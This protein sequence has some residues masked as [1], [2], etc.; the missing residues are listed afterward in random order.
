M[1]GADAGIEYFVRAAINRYYYYAFW[2]VRP[3]LEQM[4]NQQA[5]QH[6]RYTELLN[7]NLVQS[8]EQRV[9]RA[10]K[11]GLVAEA[12]ATEARELFRARA[13]DL[14]STLEQAKTV[15]NQADYD[16]DTTEYQGLDGSPREVIAAFR[17][18]CVSVEGR[19][20]ELRALWLDY[21]G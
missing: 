9:R 10:K 7:T 13:R 12:Q 8:F 2:S 16:F 4:I 5:K 21:G 6:G 14:S 11:G 18:I 17:K 19:F 1:A 3:H 15:R 20:E